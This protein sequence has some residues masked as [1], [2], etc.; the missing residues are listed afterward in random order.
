MVAVCGSKLAPET[1]RLNDCPGRGGLG[2]VVMP[3]ISGVVEPS[4]TASDM[5][6]DAVPVAPFRTVTVNAPAAGKVVEPF[7]CVAE[8]VSVAGLQAG[9]H[10]GPEKYT[11]A[12]DGSKFAPAMVNVKGCPRTG[13]VGDVAIVVS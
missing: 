4:V 1:V 7:N 3:L 2:A 9:L 12:V 11:M 5:L 6:F 13:G 8:P 10:P